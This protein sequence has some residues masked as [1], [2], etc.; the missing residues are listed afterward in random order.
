MENSESDNV[1]SSHAYYV[2]ALFDPRQSPPRLFYIGKGVGERMHDHGRE[3]GESAKLNRIRAIKAAG[4][5]YFAQRLVTGLSETDAYRVELELIASF[6]LESNGGMLTNAVQP[7]TVRRA[8]SAVKAR[9]GAEE[10]VQMALKIIKDDVVAMAE[11]NPQGITNAE[12]TN[13]LGLQS[14][15]AGGHRN[16]LSHSI[17]GVLM[18]EDRIV[19][20]RTGSDA[21]YF[22]PRNFVRC[23]E[24]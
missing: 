5:E 10:R 22:S 20:V 13:K 4:H 21:R 14:T 24:L 8:K 9:P 12:V 17:L 18:L 3:E 2:Y 15:H 7:A 19:K 23:Q 1:D 16:Y 11:L 6:G